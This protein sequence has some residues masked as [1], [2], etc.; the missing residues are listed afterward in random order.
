[1]PTD[2]GITRYDPA[3][4]SVTNYSTTDGITHNEFNRL[5]HTQ[6][7][8]GRL[9]FGG[10]NGIT[11]FDPRTLRNKHPGNGAPLVITDVRQCMAGTDRV[12][13]LTAAVRKGATITMEPG[14]RYFTV[15]MA[16]LS[17]EDPTRINYAW[18]IDGVDMDWNYQHE[19]SLRIAALPYGEHLL[20]IK[21]QGGNGTWTNELQLPLLFARPLYLRW[22]FITP[23]SIIVLTI[24]F[25]NVRARYITARTAALEQGS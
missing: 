1:M 9:Y 13:D 22:W 17:F 15:N 2:N 8:D 5:A 14:D 18:R 12:V 11:A 19:P 24:M 20:R 16:L 25:W 6:G 7:P 10:L 3:S 23:C 21:A 4:G